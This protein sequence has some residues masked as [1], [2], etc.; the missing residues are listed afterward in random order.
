MILNAYVNT[1]FSN[2]YLRGQGIFIKLLQYMSKDRAYWYAT[3]HCI[4]MWMEY[5]FNN[6][7]RELH[8]SRIG[9]LHVYTM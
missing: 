4:A 3:S 8:V 7:F 1:C 2:F 6:Q 9:V 5:V